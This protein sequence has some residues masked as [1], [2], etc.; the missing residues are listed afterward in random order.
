MI[1]RRAGLRSLIRHPW[2]ALLSVVGVA[3]G[4]GVVTA[5]DLANESAHRAFRIAAETVAGRATHRVVGG[6]AGIPEELYRTLRVGH[7]VRPSAPVVEGDVAVAGRPGE[8]L[9]L[10]G[11]DPLAEAAFRAFSPRFAAGGGLDFLMARPATGLLL[12]ETAARLGVK[13]G[14]SLTV[15][16]AGGITAVTLAGSLAAGDEVSRQGLDGVL[17]TDIATAQELLGMA[18]R[19]SRI[20][21]ILPEGGEGEAVLRSLRALLP[22]GVEVVA[23]G[24]R[25]G[26]LDRMT[27]SFRLNLSALSLLALLVGMFLIYNTTT[28]SVVRRRR[29]IGM[30]R[31][32]GVTRREIF[33]LVCGEAFLTGIAGTAAGLVLG[34]LLGEGITAL[35]TRT[36]NDLYFLLRVREVP[37]LPATLAKG[38]L[39]GIG[40]TLAAALPPAL[41][42]TGA[43]PRAV[44]TRSDLELRA[45]RLVPRAAL[46]GIVAMAAGGALLLVE[47][48]GLIASFAGLF[49]LV[50]GY[51]LAVPA[52]TA[53]LAPL[54]GAVTAR[55]AGAPGK[56]AARGVTASLSRTGVATAALVVAVSATIGVGIM[57][58]SFRLTVER[59]LENRLRADLYLSTAGTGTGRGRPPLDPALVERLAAV[60]GAAAVSMSRR[61]TIESA[62]GLTELLALQIPESVFVGLRLR[63]GRGEDAWLPF[64]R[65]EGVIVSEPYAYRHRIGKGDRLRLRTDRGER[66]FPVLGVYYDY[67]SDSGVV[68][69]GRAGYLR[70]WNDPR[71]DGMGFYAA[72]GVTVAELAARLRERAGASRVTVVS[73]RELRAA[74]MAVFD[75]TFAITGVLRLL[76]VVVAFIGILSALMAMQVERTRELAVLRALGLTPGQLWGIVCGET[77]LMGLIAG[78]LSLPLGIVQAYVLVHVVNR[79][80]FGWTMEMAVEPAILLQAILLSLAAALVAGGGP[81]LSIARTPPA[82]ALREEEQG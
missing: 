38:A 41:E 16:A 77:G 81:A 54:L 68:A 40:A 47:G 80:S 25:A 4:V 1:L 64:V 42:A 62:D 75:R 51:A 59:W 17:V 7:R 48:G 15:E 2:Q 43:P 65:G 11:V 61:V 37:L 33:L 24:A 19:L 27:R 56:M 22:P 58:A 49:V 76:T 50:I 63:E 67:G 71:V 55:I 82:L 23:A 46:A 20:D 14:G 6:P 57:V 72:P 8:T 21:L 26:A 10:V 34:L 69:M 29:L 78:L 35:V 13:A 28:F 73:N 3:L 36:I 79:R 53:I 39:L 5:V 30:L 52:A 74:S 31:A 45:R 32:V 66:E 70:F 9:L 60:P 18:G 44:L 12:P